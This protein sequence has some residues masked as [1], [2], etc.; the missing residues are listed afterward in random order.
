MMEKIMC[1]Q[2]KNAR[3][4]PPV[5]AQYRRIDNTCM[6]CLSTDICLEAWVDND[7]YRKLKEEEDNRG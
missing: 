6:S 5:A 3:L 7:E 1:K 2:A 4:E